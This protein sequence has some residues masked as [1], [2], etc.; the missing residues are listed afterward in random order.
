MRREIATYLDFEGCRT[1][2]ELKKIDETILYF[3]KY[4]DNEYKCFLE[5]KK[6]SIPGR[7]LFV[8]E[9]VKIIPP[10]KRIKHLGYIS[11]VKKWGQKLL[12]YKNIYVEDVDE[13]GRKSTNM[14]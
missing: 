5:L 12:I 11:D 13:N 2:R 14:E 10:V 1:T 9:F 8:C 3:K 6:G 7:Y 4:P